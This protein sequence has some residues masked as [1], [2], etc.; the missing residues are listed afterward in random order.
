MDADYVNDNNNSNNQENNDDGENGAEHS[1]SGGDEVEEEDEEVEETTAV[2]TVV[3]AVVPPPQPTLPSRAD[4]AEARIKAKVSPTSHDF[5]MPIV[6][7]NGH[8]IMPV[9]T[10]KLICPICVWK[11][12][13][14][15]G[16]KISS[17]AQKHGAKCK[18]Y[19]EWKDAQ[20]DD[21]E[22]PYRI[23][24]EVVELMDVPE[25]QQNQHA[26]PDHPTRPI[27][28]CVLKCACHWRIF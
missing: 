19:P 10:G 14:F 25:S 22:S 6:L 24:E 12:S 13:D 28:V 15:S 3:A 21:A 27:K 16:K 2:A 9:E 26:H 23:E 4:A 18:W 5:D 1:T 7:K 8:V 17:Y 20:H 11:F